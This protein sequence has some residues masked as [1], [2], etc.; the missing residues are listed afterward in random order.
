M[1]A[2]VA[3]LKVKWRQEG[4]S[5]IVA[6]LYVDIPLTFDVVGIQLWVIR[7]HHRATLGVYH[8]ATSYR[9]STPFKEKTRSDE[10]YFYLRSY[11]SR[12]I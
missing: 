1:C 2:V 4:Q 11:T 9:N 8:S 5:Y 10:V 12:N 7:T 6:R 3:N